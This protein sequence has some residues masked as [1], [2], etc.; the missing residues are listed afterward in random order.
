M[1]VQSRVEESHPRGVLGFRE[2]QQQG[3]RGTRCFARGCPRRGQRG[4]R[5]RGSGGGYDGE[6]GPV[7]LAQSIEVRQIRVDATVGAALRGRLRYLSGE[8]SFD[9]HPASEEQLNARVGNLGTTS[10]LVGTL[11]LE[12]DIEHG[13][14]LYAWGFL[15]HTAWISGSADPEAFTECTVHIR[16]GE[17]LVRGV[18]L[19]IENSSE[20]VPVFDKATGWMRVGAPSERD[21]KRLQVATDTL[22]GVSGGR[23]N[24]VWMR[25]TFDDEVY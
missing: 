10:L 22:V 23:I 2:N 15:P 17:V 21:Q 5:G 18:S 13:T 9:F 16:P 7:L 20:R 24:S 19:K 1:F 14:V 6:N 12:V 11:Q 8:Y 25:P 4:V 3:G